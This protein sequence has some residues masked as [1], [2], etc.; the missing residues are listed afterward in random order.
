MAKVNKNKNVKTKKKQEKYNA[1]NEIIIGVTTKPKEVRVDK[2]K[3]TRTN[4]AN[5]KENSKNS[6]KK[7][8]RKKNNVTQK[9]KKKPLGKLNKEQQIKRS[10][11]RKLLISMVILS[12]ILIGVI[13]YMM[14]T[15]AFNITDIEVTGNDKISEDTYKSLTKIEL[16]NKNIFAISKVNISNN[17]KENPYV[18]EVEIKRKLPNIIQI[19][20]KERKVAYQTKYNEHYL[21][22][23][24]QG[25]VLEQGKEKK[26][27]I[28]IE[29]LSS[30]KEVINIGQRL[31][32]DDLNKLDTVLKIV[33]Y[34]NYNSIDNKIKNIN[35]EDASNYTIHF[36]KY[37]QVA[38]LGDCSNLSERILW[39][40]TILEKEK[41]NKGE[42]FINGNLNDSKVYFRPAPKKE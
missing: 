24:E 1:D 13:I 15:P 20:V 11:K 4:G 16:N 26:D 31:N 36:S 19:N 10:N 5:K 2:K 14:I 7:K 40:K 27:I 23:D 25:Y 8:V 6:N 9:N 33:N 32:I 22:I 12:I 30:I 42:I 17:I 21:Y 28:K 29:G 38:Y 34:C 37:G 18:E 39:L 41:G 35:I 3:A